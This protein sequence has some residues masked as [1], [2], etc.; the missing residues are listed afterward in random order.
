MSLVLLLS[1]IRLE[2]LLI[3]R[4]NQN[5]VD[6]G[7]VNQN[8]RDDNPEDVHEEEVEPEVEGL[9]PGGVEIVPPGSGV[10]EEITIELAK[11]H[12][13]LE[14][15]AVRAI[16]QNAVCCDQSQWALNEGSEGFH[17]HNI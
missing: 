3:G 7:L 12:N 8:Q 9:W 4:V 10:V 17:R 11:G 2:R 15:P 16:V 13:E 5:D 14:D 1:R 6:G